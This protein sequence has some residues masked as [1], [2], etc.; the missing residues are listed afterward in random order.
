MPVIASLNGKSL[1]DG[2]IIQSRLSKRE[3]MVLS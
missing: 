3:L 2:L 1:G